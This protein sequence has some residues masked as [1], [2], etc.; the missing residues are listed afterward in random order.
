MHKTWQHTTQD[1]EKII[2]F[3]SEHKEEEKKFYKNSNHKSFYLKHS[4]GKS[5]KVKLQMYYC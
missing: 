4:G 2:Q 1:E 5:T 3:A